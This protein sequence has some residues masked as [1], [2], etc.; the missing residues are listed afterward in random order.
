MAMR[1]VPS[2]PRCFGAGLLACALLSAL[3]LAGQGAAGAGLTLDEVVRQVLAANPDILRARLLSESSRGEVLASSS[4]FSTDVQVIAGGRRDRIPE[5]GGTDPI[6]LSTESREFQAGVRRRLRSGIVL[7]PTVDFTQASEGSRANDL[8]AQLGFVVPLAKDRWGAI[9]RA[10]ETAARARYAADTLSLHHT[11]AASVREAVNAYWTYVGAHRRLA[12]RE[13]AAARA[14]RMVQEMTALVQAAERPVADLNQVLANVASKRAARL[15]AEQEVI[16]ARQRLGLLMGLPA[17]EILRLPPPAT[18]LPEPVAFDPD[19]AA[20]ERRVQAG[21]TRRADV[22]SVADEVR[23]ADVLV[24]AARNDLRPQIDLSGALRVRERA[25]GL[26]FESVNGIFDGRSP[27]L[28]A[29]VQL[30]YGFPLRNEL[31]RGRLIQRQ[32]LYRETLVFREE[33]MREAASGIMVAAEALRRGVLTMAESVRAVELYRIAVEN[34]RSK[35]QFGAGTIIDV[36]LSEDALTGAELDEVASR[37][38]YAQALAN[39]ALEEGT[40]LEYTA[41]GPVAR[42]VPSAP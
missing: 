15:A 8:N 11:A 36:L 2:R 3:P 17:R 40:L 37:V 38:L 23:A 35:Y 24:A 10:G 12:V 1:A 26:G 21:L 34:E 13:A 30:Q 28:G 16:N 9:S 42:L 25:S 7:N 31:S 32:S 14:E 29:T 27:G 22:A 41:E 6:P 4:L 33:L 19:S 39:L 5:I 18:P 20:L